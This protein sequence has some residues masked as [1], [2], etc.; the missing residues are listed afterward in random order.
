MTNSK[1]RKRRIRALAAELGI[2]YMA[3][4]RKLD[5]ER[6][7]DAGS[8]GDE[9]PGDFGPEPADPRPDAYVM[10]IAGS[11]TR[12][13][14]SRLPGMAFRTAGDIDDLNAEYD[15]VRP[16]VV[17]FTP[18][19]DSLKMLVID[20]RQGVQ[21]VEMTVVGDLI[22]AGYADTAAAAELAAT[23]Q[24]QLAGRRE[25][26][27]EARLRIRAAQSVTATLLGEVQLATGTVTDL[28]LAHLSL[29]DNPEAQ[30][31][32]R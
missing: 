4:M 7:P 26:S 20:Q 17:S 29:T 24:A 21:N 31:R 28:V 9:F 6:E 18:R 30:A 25:A 13:L 12:F 5:E 8:P 10:G 27:S 15:L 3:A 23:G 16:S 22:W 2:S 32:C 14:Q 19:T 11:V 1:S